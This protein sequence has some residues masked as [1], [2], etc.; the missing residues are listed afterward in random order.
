MRGVG[1]RFD[2]ENEAEDN[3]KLILA[4]LVISPWRP[5]RVCRAN[6]SLAELNITFF[7]V[8][9]YTESDNECIMEK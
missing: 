1:T 8:K 5:P 6:P 3:G 9:T 7:E 2:V 4:R